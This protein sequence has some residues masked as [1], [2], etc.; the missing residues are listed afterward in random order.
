MNGLTLT[1]LIGNPL[2]TWLGQSISWRYAFA[3]VAVVSM[4]TLL[5]IFI[6]VA[7]DRNQLRNRPLGELKAF[8]RPEA[9]LGMMIGV[10][11]VG[12][13][14]AESCYVAATLV[15]VTGGW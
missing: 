2:A 7:L 15:I 12:G 14:L 9:W 11:G 3:L 4:L 1:I 10:T 5:L 13:V 6:F 8:N